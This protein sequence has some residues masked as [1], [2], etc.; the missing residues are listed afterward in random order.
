MTS[1][2]KPGERLWSLDTLRGFD[3]FWIIGGDA[4][5]RTLADVTGWGW[6]RFG[7]F[8][9][10]H[11]EWAGLHFYDLIFPLFIFISGVAIPFSLL[12]KAEGGAPKTGTYGKLLKRGLILVL[13]GILYNGFMKTGPVAARYP[14]VLGQ[15]GLAYLLA[16][17]IMLNVKSFK[18]RIG[19]V[20][21]I[22]GGYSAIQLLVPV[23]GVGAGVLTPEGTINGFLDRLLLPGKLY[24]RIFDPEGVLCVLSAV[25]VTLLGGIAG[26]ILRSEKGSDYRKTGILALAGIGLAGAGIGLGHWYPIIKK[27][28]TATFDISAAGLSFLLLALFYL[29]V[30]VWKVRKWTFFFRV[31][32]LNSITIYLGKRLID[33][34]Y[35]G[36]FLFGGLARL[37]G[38][39]QPVTLI[40]GVI[41][42]EWVF[43]YFLYKKRIFLRV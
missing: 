5:F 8:Q 16:C 32:G 38:R 3:M 39:F 18:G 41:V 40:V 25:S 7:A 42:V 29:V 22:L 28:W 35:A 34:S 2:T 6:A 10:D 33:F 13:L 4:L 17:L 37:S 30:D 1:E 20:L 36:D 26:S 15:I 14:S 27:A 11:A 31:V 23:P 12:A 19:A 9:L 21:A 43:L 24:D